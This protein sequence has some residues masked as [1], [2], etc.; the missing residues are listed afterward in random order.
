MRYALCLAPLLL[1]A[2]PAFAAGRFDGWTADRRIALAGSLGNS[3][4][5]PIDAVFLE[6]DR[7]N[8]STAGD[9]PQFTIVRS[10]FD[11]R[12]I[13]IDLIPRDGE[14]I[15]LQLRARLARRAGTGTLVHDGVTHR[16]RFELER[17]DLWA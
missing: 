15:V 17:M 11:L 4:G 7:R 13:W 5:T 14:R 6:I 8:C 12:D 2:T 9:A 3:V 1:A 10:W 16:V